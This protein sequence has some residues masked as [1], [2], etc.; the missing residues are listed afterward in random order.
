MVNILLTN[1]DGIEAPGLDSLIKALSPNHDLTI[2]A[3]SRERSAVSQGF[4]FHVSYGV[5]QIDDHRV[6]VGGTPVD[7]V[8]FALT[9]WGPFD[10]V[11]SGINHGANMAWD[12]W[13]SGTVGAAC[14]AARRGIKAI[15]VSLDTVGQLEEALH[16]P[17]AARMLARYLDQGLIKIVSHGQVLNV[18]FPNAPAL[19]E[20]AP[21]WA[22]PGMY[23]YNL[24]TLKVESEKSR[25]WRVEVQQFAAYS[26]AGEGTD[27]RLIGEGPTVSLLRVAW[28]ESREE[29]CQ[30]FTQWRSRL[31]H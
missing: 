31:S 5:E 1:D 21:Q 17:Q 8:M 13:Y 25:Q 30:A 3:P 20:R 12:T 2:V 9:Q 27:G 6:R 15:A 14:E 26:G 7:C 23:C 19:M 18:N 11:I 4:S 22:V 16:Y 29:E 28:P 24:N 10:L